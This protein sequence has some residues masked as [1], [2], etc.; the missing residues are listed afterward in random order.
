MDDILSGVVK[1]DAD[2]IDDLMM[3]RSV[4]MLC[5]HLIDDYR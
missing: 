2:A 5:C 3:I 4:L 1:D